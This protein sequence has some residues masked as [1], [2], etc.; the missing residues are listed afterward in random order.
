MNAPP[1]SLLARLLASAA[2]ASALGL[3]SACS[4]SSPPTITITGAVVV[5]PISAHA[6]A[7]AYF[8]VHNPTGSDETITAVTAAAVSSHAILNNSLTGDPAATGTDIPAGATTTLGPYGPD[9]LLLNPAPLTPGSTITLTVAFRHLGPLTVPATV[10]TVAQAAAHQN[11]AAL[12][13]TGIAP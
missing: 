3:L 9:V 13:P 5:Q 1:T 2:A 7:P 8:T 12:T 6:P 4:G 10:E 11:Q